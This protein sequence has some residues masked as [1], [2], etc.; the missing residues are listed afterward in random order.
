MVYVA[1]RGETTQLYLRPLDRPEFTAIPGTDGA[2]HP[3]FSP[4]GSEVAFATPGYLKKVSLP[5]GEPRTLCETKVLTSLT[6][7]S[8]NRL[9]FD[10]HLQ[11]SRIPDDGGR[12]E[13]IG[14]PAV[15]LFA[16]PEG[17]GL[18]LTD[19]SGGTWG[20][21][22]FWPVAHFSLQGGATTLLES[23]YGARYLSTGHLLF[24]RRGQAYTVPF[25]LERLELAG[26]VVPVVEHVWIDSAWAVSQLSVSDEGTLV[27]ARGGD[28]ARTIPTWIDRQ[29]REEALALPPQV[30]GPFK[31]SPDGRRLAIQVT[32]PTS[33]IYVYDLDRRTFARLTLEGIN[34][35]PIWT[36]DGT[37][38]ICSRAFPAP[39]GTTSVG[40]TTRTEL[41]RQAVDGSGD[42]QRLIGAEDLAGAEPV[43][44]LL[45]PENVSADGTFLALV[46]YHPSRNGD[47]WVFPLDGEGEAR[48]LV[49]TEHVEGFA[50]PS[51]D[52]RWFAFM[53]DKTGRAEVFVRPF[54]EG[55]QVWQISSAGGEAVRWS[56]QG[57]EI[58]Y[59]DGRRLMAVPVATQPDFRAGTPRV[60]F[61]TDF[62]NCNGMSYDVAPDGQRFLVL[63]PVTA[64]EPITELEVVVNWF[65]ELKEKM[66]EAGQ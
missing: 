7:G 6:W 55:D 45:V 57:D 9:Y 20:R 11:L 33:Q 17:R 22:D 66:R 35:F 32:D 18:L 16:L 52:G 48:P 38:V 60:V 44:P 37:G 65:E 15:S 26:R 31:L 51:P 28:W 27:Y 19:G 63:K 43:G 14:Y 1:D 41:V 12:P 62:L 64:G 24:V 61:E 56:P 4:D 54:P 21:M 42:V 8:D 13:L 30:Y 59:R 40:E 49:A 29:G 39:K 46:Y 47:I 34:M 3:V 25:S 36:A 50:S 23:G 5:A 58:F 53:S 2:Y 10:R